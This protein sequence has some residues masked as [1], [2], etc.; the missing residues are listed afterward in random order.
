MFFFLF[1]GEVL[2]G[3]SKEKACWGDKQLW[4][5]EQHRKPVRG[6]ACGKLLEVIRDKSEAGGNLVGSCGTFQQQP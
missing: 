5:W 3:I 1:E 4:E 6:V 2:K